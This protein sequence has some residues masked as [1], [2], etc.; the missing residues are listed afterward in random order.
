MKIT[1]KKAAPDVYALSFDDTEVALEGDDVKTLL[2]EIT[3]ILAPGAQMVK[4]AQQRTRDFVRRIKNADDVGIQKFLL[5]CA[6]DDIL[7]LLKVAEDD[8]ALVRKFYGNMSERSRKVFVEDLVFKFKD[9]IPAA[10]IT[11]AIDNMS[12]IARQLEGEGTLIYENVV[13]R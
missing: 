8:K 10:R 1:V 11:A 7:V 13:S 3:R 4:N 5:L 6:R 9:E 2:V 12:E